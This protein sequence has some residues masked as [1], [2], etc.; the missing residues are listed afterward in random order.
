M[1]WICLIG[2]AS[3]EPPL[4]PSGLP[5]CWIHDCPS[6]PAADQ[7]GACKHP[8]VD[9]ECPPGFVCS[10]NAECVKGPRSYDGG[11]ACGTDAGVDDTPDAQTYDWP[12][13]D[14]AHIPGT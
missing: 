2:C 4:S 5:Y 11:V 3:E 10:C 1:S 14:E 12:A 8:G 9:T 6:D 13:C 7:C